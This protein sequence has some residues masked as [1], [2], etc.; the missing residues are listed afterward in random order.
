MTVYN[1]PGCSQWHAK[2]GM[3]DRCL[4]TNGE[5]VEKPSYEIGDILRWR[6]QPRGL[7]YKITGKVGDW[8]QLATTDGS[9]KDWRIRKIEWFERADD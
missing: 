2:E 4:R 6:S 5:K 3:C 9:V 7:T 1:C 8:Y